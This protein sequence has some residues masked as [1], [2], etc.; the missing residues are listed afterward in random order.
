[1]SAARPFDWRRTPWLP[2]YT[3]LV[4]VFLYAPL[5]VLVA[6]SFNGS[7]EA[8]IWG[9][10]SLRWFASV[11]EN[12]DISVSLGHS[13]VIAVASTILSTGIA[14]AGALGLVR[15]PKR[16]GTPWALGI[17]MLPLIVPEIVVAVATLVFFS[18]IG[19]HIGLG[20]LIIAH[21]V[22]CIPFALL[23]IAAR[24]RE[25]GSAVEDAARDLYADE[26]RVFKRVTLPLLMPAVIAGAM[27]A[28]VSS[29]DDFMISMMVADAGQTTLPV[30]IYGMMRLGVTPEVNAISALLLAASIAIVIMSYAA[31]RWSKARA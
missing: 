5:T 21:T 10:F 24:L 8:T 7:R 14:T 16:D 9:G 2:A 29:L 17:I 3:V 4:F 11:F 13:L 22:F 28:F 20:N 27:L 23:P 15:G 30:Y 31:T 26:W 6:Y 19:L 1:M 12:P 18:A 25:I